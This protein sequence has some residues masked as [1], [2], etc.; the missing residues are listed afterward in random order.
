MCVTVIALYPAWTDIGGQ[1][2]LEPSEAVQ[3]HLAGRSGQLRHERA[4]EYVS[5]PPCWINPSILTSSDWCCSK[6][7]ERCPSTATRA[8]A[9]RGFSNPA[10][11]SPALDPAF[12]RPVSFV[13][14]TTEPQRPRGDGVRGIV[15]LAVGVVLGVALLAAV[16][17]GL[18]RQGH[19]VKKGRMVRERAKP[20][21]VSAETGRTEMPENAVAVLH[22]MEAVERYEMEAEAKER[23]ELCA[24]EQS[25]ME[26]V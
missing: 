23:G 1:R 6:E 25:V 18:W 4:A 24:A 11:L 8:C 2:M 26:T 17:Y 7:Y 14:P 20:V 9:P 10:R 12:P 19:R 16:V 21:E 13:E 22:E 5:R 3:R 15:A